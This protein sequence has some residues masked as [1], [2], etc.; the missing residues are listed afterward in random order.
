MSEFPGDESPFGL[1]HLG[2][3]ARAVLLTD[4][5]RKV[6]GWRMNRGRFWTNSPVNA[7]IDDRSG[8]PTDFVN[9]SFGF[10][11]ACVVALA[12]AGG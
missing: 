12:R 11:L 7:R 9:R 2:G 10:R 5:A 4:A 3:N 6:S 8:T 1:R